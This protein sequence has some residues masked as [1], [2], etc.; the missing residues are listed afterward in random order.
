MDEKR[1]KEDTKRFS[2]TGGI[3]E[4]GGIIPWLIIKIVQWATGAGGGKMDDFLKK[5]ETTLVA[6]ILV[7]FY[8]AVM[9]IIIFDCRVPP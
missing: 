2:G 8:I 7:I 4:A 1:V 5:H 3:A 6:I 9:L